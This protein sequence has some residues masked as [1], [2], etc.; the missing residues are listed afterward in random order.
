MLKS[1]IVLNVPQFKHLNGFF[2]PQSE[3]PECPSGWTPFGQ[4]CYQLQTDQM[5]MADA[6]KLCKARHGGANVVEDNTDNERQFLRG[7][8]RNGTENIWVIPYRYPFNC[9]YLRRMDSREFFCSCYENRFV[10]CEFASPLSK[11]D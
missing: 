2:V 6:E 11:E 4:H 5:N 10:M 9:R 8:M 1:Y 7:L 3:T